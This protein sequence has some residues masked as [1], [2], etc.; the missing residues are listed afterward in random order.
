MFLQRLYKIW[1][2]ATWKYGWNLKLTPTVLIKQVHD[3]STLLLPLKTFLYLVQTYP[4]HLQKH[5]L[6]SKVS[7]YSPTRHFMTGGSIT[8]AN[9]YHLATPYPS[10]QPCKII[11]NH[12]D[13][14]K[15]CKLHSR[16]TVQPPAWRSPDRLVSKKA[17][18]HRNPF[19]P[20]TAIPHC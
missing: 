19:L 18:T 13:Y 6:L 11:L 17:L 5:R 10:T 9:Q 1:D 14:G 12:H 2:L 4:M 3:Y 15:A 20:H 8:N 7:T 16:R